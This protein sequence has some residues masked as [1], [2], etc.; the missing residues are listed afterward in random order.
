MTGSGELEGRS[1]FLSASIPDSAR[2]KGPFNPLEITD[3][4]VAVARAV[5]QRGGSLV[6]AAHPTIAPLLLYVAAEEGPATRPRVVVYQSAVFDRVLPEA[7]LRFEAEGVGSIVRT[8][9]MAGEPADATRAPQSLD[10]MR[11]QMLTEE[12]PVGAIFVGGMSGIPNE[13]LLFRELR[14]GE[15]TYALGHPG[16]AAS[17][18]VNESPSEMREEL[19]RDDVYPA[20]ARRIINDLV[21][22]AF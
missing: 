14:D 20:L 4:V 3:A 11:R 12:A 15:P 6:T 21:G 5:L 18:L 22:R 7:T 19:A 2:W 17:T 16:G 8:A 9:A 13:H 10:L 1:V